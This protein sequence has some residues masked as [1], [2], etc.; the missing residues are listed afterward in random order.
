M[1]ILPL[2]PKLG[3]F[4][5]LLRSAPAL[6]LTGAEADDG[7][8]IGNGAVSGVAMGVGVGAAI[9]IGVG[10]GDVVGFGV[11]VEVSIGHVVDAGVGGCG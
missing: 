2:L 1:R 10:V 3:A 7:H 6:V 8:R 9:D 4:C 11:R 5:V